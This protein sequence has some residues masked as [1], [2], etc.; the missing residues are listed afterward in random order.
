[1]LC[2]L[3]LR[4]GKM[5]ANPSQIAVTN[6]ETTDRNRKPTA[7]ITHTQARVLYFVEQQSGKFEVQLFVGSLV[8]ESPVACM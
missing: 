1:M 5:P 6:N 2:L 8:L 4:N 7:N 3:Q